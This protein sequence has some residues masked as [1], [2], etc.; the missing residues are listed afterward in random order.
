MSNIFVALKKKKIAG[1]AQNRG[2]IPRVKFVLND[3]EAVC[4]S[5]LVYDL[6]CQRFRHWLN[7]KH[8]QT[9]SLMGGGGKG[10]KSRQVCLQQW[11]HSLKLIPSDF[12]VTHRAKLCLMKTLM[13]EE[14]STR[15]HNYTNL[16][17]VRVCHRSLQSEPVRIAHMHISPA[18]KNVF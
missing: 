7:H 18:H 1:I 16:P 6:L 8:P 17:R 15:W 13:V 2:T 5:V 11:K 10:T 14:C 12:L 3:P 4:C 9:T